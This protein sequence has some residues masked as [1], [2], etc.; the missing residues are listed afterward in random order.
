MPEGLVRYRSL[1]GFERLLIVSPEALADVLIHKSY[2]FRKPPFVVRLLKQILG[3]GILL[4]EGN[5]HRIQR[6]A[7]LPA[8]AF[9]HIK[10]LY[11]VMWRM[12]ERLIMTM[13][14]DI[15]SSVSARVDASAYPTDE[16]QTKNED[17]MFTVNISD[18]ASRATLDIIG[19]AGMGRDF[20]AICN[21]NNTLH[22]AYSLLVQSSKEATL[23]GILRLLLPDWV[24]N[25][26]PLKR[27]TQANLAIQLVRSLCQEMIREAKSLNEGHGFSSYGD[28]TKKNILTVAT[29][30]GTFTDEL[31][32][33]QLMTF[34][35]AGHE[36]TATALTWAIYIIC[37]YPDIQDKLRHEVWSRLPRHSSTC[38]GIPGDLSTI[39]DSGTPYLNAVCLEVFRYFSPIPVTF[40]EATKDTCILQTPVSAGTSIVLAPRVTNRDSTLWGPDAQIF[41]PDRWVSLKKRDTSTGNILTSIASS[42]DPTKD[43]EQDIAAQ[44]KSGHR[45]NLAMMTFLHGPRSCIGQSFARAELAILLASLVGHFE[46]K[47][48]K[49][50]PRNERDIK[51]SRG[52]TARPEKGLWVRIRAIE[53]VTV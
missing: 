50:T 14:E 36:T 4:A 28:P 24:V 51:V 16:N 42:E 1:L 39:I 33:D 53:P 15:Q 46:F 30:S 10:E 12:G 49:E 20:G 34:L 26:I 2:E 7:L 13:T 25:C 48:T 45:K 3:R 38:K 29:A 47:L 27:N 8:F 19:V 44:K 35:A 23:I 41:N 43:G 9:R 31:L 17:E 6:K 40:R 18:L 32:V 11:P 5:E 22:Q 37:L 52:A 21:P